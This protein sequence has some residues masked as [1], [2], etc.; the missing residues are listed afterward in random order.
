MGSHPIDHRSTAQVAK[1]IESR[2]DS[3]E[4]RIGGV[5]NRLQAVE[6]DRLGVKEILKHIA[7]GLSAVH[8]R[9]GPLQ[10]VYEEMPQI[11]A[12][13][14]GKVDKLSGLVGDRPC[15][16]SGDCEVTR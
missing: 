13:V 5:E 2:L 6:E 16:A 7:Q 8:E 12:R 4:H 10:S 3:L 11:L 9:L 1:S 15:L 14:E